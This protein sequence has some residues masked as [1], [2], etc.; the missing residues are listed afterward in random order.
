MQVVTSLVAIFLPQDL[1]V[2]SPAAAISAQVA[3]SQ[4]AT[5]T[6]VEKS[7]LLAIS[8]LLTIILVTVHSLPELQLPALMLLH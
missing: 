2:I 6:L 4:V 8:Q 3:T 1:V 5:Y 7:A